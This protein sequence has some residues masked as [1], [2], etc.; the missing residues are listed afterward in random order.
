MDSCERKQHK[1]FKPSENPR[2]LII[3]G[4]MGMIL[5]LGYYNIRPLFYTPYY[6][7]D[8]QI[9]FKHGETSETSSTQARAYIQKP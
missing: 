3:I 2:I 1:H 4:L 6:P 8:L 7:E 5:V 9:D